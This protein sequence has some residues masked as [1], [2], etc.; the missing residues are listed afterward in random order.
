L[1]AAERNL[2]IEKHH[3]EQFKR[4]HASPFVIAASKE[5]RVRMQMSLKELEAKK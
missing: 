5:V 2:Q 4:K 3:R 1:F